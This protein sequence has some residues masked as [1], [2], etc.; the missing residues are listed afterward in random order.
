VVSADCCQIVDSGRANRLRQ[1][2]ALSPR[3]QEG[4]FQAAE[5]RPQ[6]IEVDDETT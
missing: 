1:S 6:P 2:A 3:P 5:G 4:A